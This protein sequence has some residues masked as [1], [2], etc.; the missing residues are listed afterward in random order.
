[1]YASLSFLVLIASGLW[2][3]VL[4][5]EEFV[6]NRFLAN[7]FFTIIVMWIAVLLTKYSKR[8]GEEND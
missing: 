4:F 5:N 3:M 8:R 7:G 6:L 1:L 2:S